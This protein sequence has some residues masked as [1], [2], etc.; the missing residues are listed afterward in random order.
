MP[1][2][3]VETKAGSDLVQLSHQAGQ[4][5]RRCIIRQRGALGRSL[6]QEKMLASSITAP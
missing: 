3:D 4:N 6:W 1:W 2:S 5:Y